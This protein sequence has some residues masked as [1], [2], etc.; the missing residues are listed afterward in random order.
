MPRPLQLPYPPAAST[1]GVPLALTVV[2]PKAPRELS[3]G[4]VAAK[5]PMV[6]FQISQR[7]VAVVAADPVKPPMTSTF[8]LGSLSAP[9]HQR[10]VAMLPVVCQSGSTSTG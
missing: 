7:L 10:G 9:C 5:V 8:P 2:Q 3:I 1:Y 6:G 4:A